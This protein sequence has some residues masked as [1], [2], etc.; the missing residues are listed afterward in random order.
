MSVL[1]TEL[2]DADQH[3]ACAWHWHRQIFAVLQLFRATK[4]G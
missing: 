1:L 2:A 4:P 3:F